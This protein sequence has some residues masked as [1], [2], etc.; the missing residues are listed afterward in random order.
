MSARWL[1]TVTSNVISTEGSYFIAFEQSDIVLEDTDRSIEDGDAFDVRVRVKDER[2]LDP[3]PD[4]LEEDNTDIS[5]FYEVA[6]VSFDYQEAT[7]EF[8]TPVEV[9]AAENQSVSGTTNVAP[10]QEISVR[11]RSASGVSPG[12][13]QT[14]EDVTVTADGEFTASGL[15]LKRRQPR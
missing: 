7:G 8:N 2:L 11:V 10:G 1:L 12:F 14:A 3:D 13:V 9:A 6:T 4:E 5:D 15:D